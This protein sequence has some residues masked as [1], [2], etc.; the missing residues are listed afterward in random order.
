MPHALRHLLCLLRIPLRQQYHR[1]ARDLHRLPLLRLVGGFGIVQV[2]ECR[3]VGRQLP[4]VVEHPLA[5]DLPIEGG[6][7]RCPLLHE[8]GK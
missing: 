7:A 2:I 5:V 1:I 4:F 6:M 8:F 3:Q